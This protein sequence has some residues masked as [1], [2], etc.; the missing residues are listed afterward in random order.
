MRLPRIKTWLRLVACY[1]LA[2]S[3]VFFLDFRYMKSD[4][5]GLAGCL[6]TLPLSGFVVTAWLV[7]AIWAERHGFHLP[8][9]DYHLEC[10]FIACALLNAVIF[11]PLYLFWVSRKRKRAYDAPPPPPDVSHRA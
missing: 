11:Y 5:A 8:I 9:N 6:F 4:W 10:A 3:V 1:W 7:A 2:M